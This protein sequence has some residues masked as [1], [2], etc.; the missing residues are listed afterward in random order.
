MKKKVT[1]IIHRI[2]I[3]KGSE[4]TVR[5]KDI[6]VNLLPDDEINIVRDEGHTSENESWD[7]C[8][9]LIILREREETDKEYE[10]RKRR[11]ERDAKWSKE[12]RYENYLKLKEEFEP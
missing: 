8:T 2:Y 11:E 12:R 4:C 5:I 6:P 3:G 10:E 7:A 1:D 9:K